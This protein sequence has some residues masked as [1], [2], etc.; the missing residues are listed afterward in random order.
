M[1]ADATIIISSNFECISARSVK[2]SE[3]SSSQCPNAV[4]NCIFISPATNSFEQVSMGDDEREIHSPTKRRL[5]ALV[6]L[7]V[8]RQH[9]TQ[10]NRRVGLGINRHHGVGSSVEKSDG[11]A[12]LPLGIRFEQRCSNT[13]RAE[14]HN[15]QLTNEFGTNDTCTVT[16]TAL[17]GM[18]RSSR[19]QARATK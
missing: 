7:S 1:I 10:L 5:E 3:G 9:I 18:C 11:L 15:P 6:L 17:V 12:N 19:K 8:R 14:V 2:S 16:G 4:L 13:C